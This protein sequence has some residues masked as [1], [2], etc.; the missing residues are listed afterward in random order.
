M[1]KKKQKL[2]EN[3]GER[4]FLRSGYIEI[5]EGKIKKY[6]FKKNIF[7]TLIQIEYE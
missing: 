2:E 3:D 5:P 1:V 4:K 7:R 6:I